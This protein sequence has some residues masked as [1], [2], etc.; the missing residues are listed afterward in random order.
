M[1][2]PSQSFV[3]GFTPLQINRRPTGTGGTIEDKGVAGPDELARGSCS[4]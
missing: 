3:L 4:G 1:G 2:S